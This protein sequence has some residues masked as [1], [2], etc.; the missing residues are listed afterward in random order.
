MRYILSR[1]AAVLLLTLAMTSSAMA[2]QDCEVITLD[3]EKTT[4]AEVEDARFH[5]GSAF[6]E[7]LYDEAPTRITEVDGAPIV[8]VMC[9]RN[10]LLPT[11]RDLPIIQTGLPFSLSQDFDSA[12]S[13][14]LTIFDDGTAYR[15][16][17]TGPPALGPDS[18]ALD[19]VMEIFN[20]QRLTQ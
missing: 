13:G 16:A 10:D 3:N 15:A 19:N 4:K 11:L 9:K 5:N 17:Y 8:A 7:S 6:I 12:E 1:T 20:F 18:N 2:A 14:L